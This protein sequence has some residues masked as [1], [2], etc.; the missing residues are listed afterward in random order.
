VQS[1][2]DWFSPSSNSGESKAVVMGY[3]DT[4]GGTA[5]NRIF[6]LYG[7]SFTLNSAKTVKSIRLPSNGNVVIVAISLVPNWPPT[8]SLKPFTLP[9]ANAGQPYSGTIATNA[10]DLNGGTLTYAKV[11]G[12][13]WLSVSSAGFLSG[14]PLSAN[15]GANSFVVSVT[16]SGGLSNTATM[17]LTVLPAPPIVASILNATNGL[18]FN[19]TGGIAPY[20]VQMC[21]DLAASN[22]SNVGSPISSNSFVILPTNPATFY[23]LT[24]Q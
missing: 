22:W 13:T 16:D 7:Y 11:T 12:Q 2:S 10:S 9:V 24:G 1:L 14:T 6:Y 8:F 23:R 15:V 4:S 19:W 20:Q 3:R 18:W 21:P 5:D 17:N